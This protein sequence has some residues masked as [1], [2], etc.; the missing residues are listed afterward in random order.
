MGWYSSD[1]RFFGVAG[2]F[3]RGLDGMVGSSALR[4]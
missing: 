2:C 1:G 4:G 3:G